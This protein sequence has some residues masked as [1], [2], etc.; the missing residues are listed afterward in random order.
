MFAKYTPFSPSTKF[1]FCFCGFHRWHLGDAKLDLARQMKRIP[2]RIPLSS[3]QRQ[4]GTG[5]KRTF[6]FET[7][8][9]RG[10]WSLLPV[11]MMSFTAS[12]TGATGTNNS[13]GF[14]RIKLMCPWWRS[15]SP[16]F[17][18]QRMDLQRCA[19]YAGGRFG[20]TRRLWTSFWGHQSPSLRGSNWPCTPNT[21][22]HT[23]IMRPSWP[24][25]EPLEGDSSWMLRERRGRFCKKTSP[26]WC[27]TLWPQ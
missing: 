12:S 7:S 18:I 27:W 14:Q 1:F 19:L 9:R 24:S 13:T 25:C 4:H 16:T 26:P 21:S 2:P 20:L 6:I 23:K 17:M 5:I 11:C 8:F 3:F 22:T 15:S 10:T